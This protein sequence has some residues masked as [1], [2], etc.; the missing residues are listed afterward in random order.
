M[1]GIN[2]NN[3][4][5]VYTISSKTLTRYSTTIYI[6]STVRQ[7]QE[8]EALIASFHGKAQS[9]QEQGTVLVPNRKSPIRLTP[10]VSSHLASIQ[11]NP[12]IINIILT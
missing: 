4:W 12:L 1:L 10:L 3:Y 7:K 6:L 11:K 8:Q 5:I 2:G 9:A